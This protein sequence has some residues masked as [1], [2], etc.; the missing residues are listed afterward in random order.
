M[1]FPPQRT[2]QYNSKVKIIP[3]IVKGNGH[4]RY[5][6]ELKQAPVYY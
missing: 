5:K 1:L 2:I 3:V 6:Q 4:L